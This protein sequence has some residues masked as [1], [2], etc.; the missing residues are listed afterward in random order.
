MFEFKYI[1]D[2]T[3]QTQMEDAAETGVRQPGIERRNLQAFVIGCGL[4]GF[5]VYLSWSAAGA[6][7]NGCA[8]VLVSRW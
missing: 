7:A 6:L 1:P 4:V 3:K 2:L 8:R 5:M